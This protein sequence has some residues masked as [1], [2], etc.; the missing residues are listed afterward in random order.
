MVG[1]SNF[2]HAQYDA[3]G[4]GIDDPQDVLPS[5]GVTAPLPSGDIT[6]ITDYL[7]LQKAIDTAAGTE[8][9]ISGQTYIISQALD[10]RNNSCLIFGPNARIKQA[11]KVVLPCVFVS[12]NTTVTTTDTSLLRVGM[13]VLD[14]A[15]DVSTGNL[16]GAIPVSVK[17]ASIIGPTTFTLSAAPTA[18]ATRNLSF[19][20]DT[21][22]IQAINV[23]N[24]SLTCPGGWAYLD[25]NKSEAYPY[26]TNSLDSVGNGLRLVST[27]DFL[28]DGING[29]NARFHGVIGVGECQRGIYRRWR[30]YNNGFRGLHMHS[31]GIVGN[32]TPLLRDITYEYVELEGNGEEAFVTVRENDVLNSGMFAVFEGVVNSQASNIICRNERGNGFHVTG[33]ATGTAFD[34]NFPSRFAHVANLYLEGC[35]CGIYTAGKITNVSF[36]NVSISGS[37]I[38]IST[39]VSTLAAAS[40]LDYFMSASGTVKSYKVKA[41]QVPAGS[42]ASLGIRSGMRCIMSSGSTGIAGSGA[43]TLKTQIGAGA[44]GTDL[45]WIYNESDPINNDPYTTAASGLYVYFYPCRDYGIFFYEAG[46]YTQNIKFGNVQIRDG[47]RYGIISQY[48]S[49]QIRLRDISFGSLS[50]Y[51]T[52]IGLQMNSCE[53]LSI[54]SFYCDSVGNMVKH[55]GGASGS[56]NNF[57]Q[58]CADF[59][60]SSFRTQ[61]TIAATNDN[62]AIRCDADCRNGYIQAISLRKPSSGDTINILTTSGAP[63][64]TAGKSGPIILENPTASDGTALTVAGTHITRTAATACIV[65]RPVDAP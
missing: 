37:P 47:G 53:G 36:G 59:S 8:L 19:H 16:V 35:G 55:A 56:Y 42:V 21:N 17:V 22:C 43:I 30:G 20:R 44:G 62:E 39:N 60:I 29:C 54:G 50:I 51:G 45:V 26:Y 6:G 7:N 40:T 46:Q 12:G 9:Y 49:S 38:Y 2:R 1:V 31:E 23:S 3:Q 58:N 34:P 65:T 10:L 11:N 33:F 5:Y 57:L 15:I 25:G 27:K 48:S 63:A 28:I 64:N 52:S 14:S 41:V 13:H 61:H 4:V 18:S 24:W 32:A